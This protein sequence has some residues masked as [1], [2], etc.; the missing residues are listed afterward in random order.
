MNMIESGKKIR[1]I[2]IIIVV[3]DLQRYGGIFE[4]NVLYTVQD[5]CRYY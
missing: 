1:N 4:T 5:E 2:L 3:A